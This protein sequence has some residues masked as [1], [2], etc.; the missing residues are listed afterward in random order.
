MFED[1]DCVGEEITAEELTDF[2]FGLFTV[3]AAQRFEAE[4]KRLYG[5]LASP[6]TAAV[7]NALSADFAAL[8]PDMAEPLSMFGDTE[9]ILSFYRSGEGMYPT[10]TMHMFWIHQNAPLS[11]PDACS[12]EEAGKWLLFLPSAEADDAW[13][14]IRDATAAGELGIGAKAST[15]R[16]GTGARD[17]RL[18]IYVFTKSWE[19]E[20]DVMR[21]REQL[22]AMG[23]TDRIGYKRNIDTYAG[24]YREKGKRVTYYSV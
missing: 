10:R 2:A 16:S 20:A 21:V 9:D 18:V 3:Y 12:R 6:D 24:E 8:C 4:G 13:V 22:K 14:K 17:E 23:F 11:T 7:L 19:D 1:E 15:A 5:E